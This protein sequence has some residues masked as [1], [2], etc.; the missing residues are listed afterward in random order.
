MPKVQNLFLVLINNDFVGDYR[1]VAVC[2]L[3]I[4]RDSAFR[5]RLLIHHMPTTT[6]RRSTRTL[7]SSPTRVTEVFSVA[8]YKSPASNPGKCPRSRSPGSPART[9]LAFRSENGRSPSN[10]DSRSW[11]SRDGGSN[12]SDGSNPCPYWDRA[13]VKLDAKTFMSTL[14]SSRDF[15]DQQMAAF[16]EVRDAEVAHFRK[17][18]EA[19][20][21]RAAT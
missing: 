16:L 2:N 17:K 19:S 6:A 4:W 3:V 13:E 15:K 14:A 20:E 9:T 12:Q 7:R 1:T 5:P 8:V 18:L 10:D 11:R 21:Q